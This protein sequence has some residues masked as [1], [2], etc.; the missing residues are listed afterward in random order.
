MT[1]TATLCSLPTAVPI[2]RRSKH[3]ITLTHFD[4]VPV[5]VVH[6]GLGEHGVVLE[7]GSPDGGAVVGDQDQLGLAL[8][9]GLQGLLVAYHT[10]SVNY[11]KDLPSLY[12]PDLMT[13]A[14][15]WFMFSCCFFATTALIV[16]PTYSLVLPCHLLT[17]F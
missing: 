10:H 11:H 1:M 8:S 17:F 9:E 3:R 16:L 14:S 2:Q 7:L 15:F 5:E 13:K 6:L 4:V 12:L